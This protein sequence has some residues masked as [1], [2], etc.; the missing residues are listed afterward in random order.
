M[1]S[2]N[3]RFY[4]ADQRKRDDKTDQ[5]DNHGDVS[6]QSVMVIH[7]QIVGAVS[8]THRQKEQR[9][10]GQPHHRNSVQESFAV[11]QQQ[12]RFGKNKQHR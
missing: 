2:W 11:K 10:G 1:L 3:L 12:Q 4:H 8:R 6:Q 5:R 7:Q 9:Q